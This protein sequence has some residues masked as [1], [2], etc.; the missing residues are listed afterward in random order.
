M[1]GSGASGAPWSRLVR[2]PRGGAV[3]R[4]RCRPRPSTPC[5]SPAARP[6][7]GCRR[8]PL[9]NSDHPE[10]YWHAA[11]G[12]HLTSAALAVCTSV[13]PCRWWP[14][15][16]TTPTTSTPP[17]G[18]RWILPCSDLSLQ[19]RSHPEAA[20]LG[21]TRFTELVERTAVPVFALGGMTPADCGTR[22]RSPRSGDAERRLGLMPVHARRSAAHAAVVVRGRL[23]RIALDRI[24]VRGPGA[25]ALPHAFGS[26]RAEGA[27]AVGRAKIPCA[28]RTWDSRSAAPFQR[29]AERQVEGDVAVGGRPAAED[30]RPGW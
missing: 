9:V 16:V 20:A 15:P 27:P 25:P 1:G 24:G 8:Q 18:W 13:R 6:P 4:R 17:T 23:R 22:G 3:A 12:V 29:S 26:V 21:W 30:S 2:P 19:T 11:D 7:S 5:S 28:A 10:R 14:P